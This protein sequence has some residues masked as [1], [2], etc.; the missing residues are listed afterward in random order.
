MSCTP[1]TAEFTFQINGFT[2]QLTDQSSGSPSQWNWTFSNGQ[3]SNL[4]N[5]E[6]TFTQPGTYQICLQTSGICGESLTTCQDVT[7]NCA[8]PVALFSITN[9]GTL[10]FFVDASQNQ[11]TQWLWNFGDGN[12]STQQNPLHLFPGNGI[13]TV[14][15]IASNACGADT[16]CQ[17]AVVGMVATLEP[18]AVDFFNAMP[19]P[20]KDELTVVAEALSPEITSVSLANLQGQTVFFQKWQIGEGRNTLKFPIQEFPPGMYLLILQGEKGRNVL[21]ILIL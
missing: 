10:Q 3:S 14:C 17:N 13:F 1:P 21:K 20:V 15:L 5:P 2:I 4:Q 18:P 19:N 7:V 16:I 12:T 11:P 6:V 8:T 9:A